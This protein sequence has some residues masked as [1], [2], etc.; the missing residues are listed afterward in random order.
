LRHSEVTV[1]TGKVK[2]FSKEKGF[3]FIAGDDGAE[4]FLHVTALPVDVTEIKPGTRVD[5][6]VADGRRGPSALAVVILDAAPSVV[7]AKRKPATEMA[8]LVEDL[9]KHLDRMGDD[10]KRG[11]YPEGKK[12]EMTAKMLRAVADDFEA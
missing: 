10:L 2:F 1:P 5:Y 4:V 7:K 12:A 6:G 11:R 3:G 8:T 9:V